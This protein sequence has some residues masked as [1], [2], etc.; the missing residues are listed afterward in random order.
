MLFKT[1]TR[2]MTASFNDMELARAQGGI[3]SISLG[4][5][6]KS[7]FEYSV[8]FRGTNYG[9]ADEKEA[10]GTMLIASYAILFVASVLFGGA[11]Y[12]CIGVK[13]GLSD[14]MKEPLITNPEGV[15]A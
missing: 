14:N 5:S 8:S 3:A 9:F 11:L 10:D 13:R 4:N 15:A 2:M 7:W 12:R 6:T 1:N